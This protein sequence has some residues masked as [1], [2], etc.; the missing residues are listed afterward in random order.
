MFRRNL[1]VL[2]LALSACA[3]TE[4]V[5]LPAPTADWSAHRSE[6]VGG[7]IANGDPAVVAVWVGSPSNGESFCTGTLIGAKT[8]LTA[9]HCIYA[10]GQSYPYYVMFGTYAYQPTH[11][12][13]VQQ[14]YRHPSYNGS[15]HD[16]G[17]LRLATA[18]TNVTPIEPNPTPL[19]S[20]DVGKP[21]RHVGFGVT[22]GSGGGGG[23]KREVSYTLRQV[24]QLTIESGGTG[25]QTCGGDSGG[26][27]FMVTAGSSA[28]RVV[29]VVSYGDEDCLQYGIDSRVDVDLQ[30]IQSTMSAWEAPTCGEDGK[31]VQGCTPVDQDCAC[32]AD[33]QCTAACQKIE[34][35]PD[36]PVNCRQNGICA[37]ESCPSPDVDCVAEGG[38]CTAE[39]QCKTRQCVTDPQRTF[40]YCSRRCATTA[41]CP[42]GMQCNNSVCLLEQKPEVNIGEACRPEKDFCRNRGVCTGPS[43]N[44]LRCALPCG[45]QIDCPSDHTCEGGYDGKRYCRSSQPV[46]VPK[47]LLVYLPRADAQGP[48]ATGCTAAGGGPIMFALLA[49]GRLLRRR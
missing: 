6:I 29:G 22:S 26:P 11:Y 18:V 8:V 38:V 2:S 28:E 24:R 23:V 14:Q 40:F 47:H 41:E 16:I 12:A 1:L 33:G 44:E 36:C 42:A 30:W 13:Q 49:L 39:V 17:L 20:A 34:R 3:P 21:I 37:T 45:S 15:T 10:Y 46:V 31:C 5:E 48:V 43:A 32:A 25:K 35:D 27:A 19:T 7:T 4:D 9:A